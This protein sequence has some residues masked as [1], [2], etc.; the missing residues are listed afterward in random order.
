MTLIT[1]NNRIKVQARIAFLLMNVP[2]L[3][4]VQS[5]FENPL[6]Y[7]I[8]AI[9]LLGVVESSRS[10]PAFFGDTRGRERS[11]E[12]RDFLYTKQQDTFPS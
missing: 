11:G 1:V 6:D 7:K 5:T 12:K 8:G 4:V 9:K 2:R 3:H 10:V